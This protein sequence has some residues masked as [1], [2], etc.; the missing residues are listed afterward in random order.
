MK[1]SSGYRRTP[2]TEC[3]ICNKPLYRRPFELKQARFSACML[4]RAEAQKLYGQTSAQIEALKLGRAKGTNHREG[5]KHSEETKRKMSISIK[6]WCAENPELVKARGAKTR[7]PNHYNWKGGSTR[8]NVSIRQMT[9][10]R[11]W[12]DGVKDR[13][14]KCT[15]CGSIENL[16]SHHII[17]LSVLIS[18]YQIKNREDAR[19]TPGLWDL[20]NGITLCQRCH[21]D[22]HG[23][24]YNN[25]GSDIQENARASEGDV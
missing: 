2:N 25:I 23:R 9:E 4:H 14:G 16:E 15:R 13:D 3:I 6:R 12:M 19:N 22:Q 11:Q 17:D 1:S 10:H 21:Y 20:E 8:L 18:K 24:N 5:T 7:G